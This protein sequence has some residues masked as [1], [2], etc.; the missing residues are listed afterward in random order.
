M[1]DTQTFV[2]DCDVV[3]ILAKHIGKELAAVGGFLSLS[4][5]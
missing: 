5:N 1:P 4:R 3:S 2:L